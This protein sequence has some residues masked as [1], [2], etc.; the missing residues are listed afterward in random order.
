LISCV[1][2]EIWFSIVPID[3]Y[4]IHC[5]E[6]YKTALLTPDKKLAEVAEEMKID[7]IAVNQ[8]DEETE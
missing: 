7:V 6:K 3:A 5:A 8:K 2:P 1:Y 4:L